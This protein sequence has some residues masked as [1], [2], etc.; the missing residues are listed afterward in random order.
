M[1]HFEKL[2]FIIGSKHEKIKK[3]CNAPILTDLENLSKNIEN[4]E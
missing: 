3:E 2:I 4:C 1:G